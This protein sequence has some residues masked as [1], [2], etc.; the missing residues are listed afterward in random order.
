MK[1]LERKGFLGDFKSFISNM[2]SRSTTFLEIGDEFSEGIEV[3]RGVRQGN[4][5]LSPILCIV[6]DEL[7]NAIPVEVGY[8]LS[9]TSINATAYAD[10]INIITSSKF[11]M[12][13]ALTALQK[14]GQARNLETRVD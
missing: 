1:A 12:Q 14:T 10:D 13:K 2:Y 9:G 3:R 8:L 7:L 4:P 5:L 11:G 6:A